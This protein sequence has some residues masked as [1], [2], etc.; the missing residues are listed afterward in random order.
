[1]R[2]AVLASIVVVILVASVAITYL[3][4]QTEAVPFTLNLIPDKLK[5]E[6]IAGQQVVFLVSITSQSAQEVKISANAQNSAVL[7][8]PETISTGQ[9][10]EVTV[11]PSVRGVGNNVIVIVNGER[12]NLRQSRTLNFTVAPGEDSLGDHARQLREM[13]VP[14]FATNRPELGITNDTQWMGTIVSPVWLVVSHYLFFSKDWEMHVYW[15]V[16]IPPYDWARVDL[17]HRFT[18]TIPSLSFEISSLNASLL[19]QPIAPP[20]TVWR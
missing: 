9:V 4:T 3:F 15:H 13:F 18:E 7:I 14:W 19:P 17:R 8:E 11:V 1:L 20:V 12:G 6:T 10:A 2:R 5:G 16:M